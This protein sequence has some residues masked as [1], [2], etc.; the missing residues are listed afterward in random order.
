[1]PAEMHP[2]HLL[3]APYC[4]HR[5]R[6]HAN[7]NN[8]RQHRSLASALQAVAR[9]G[10]QKILDRD[11]LLAAPLRIAHG[12]VS[13]L[14]QIRWTSGVLYDIP[15]KLAEGVSPDDRLRTHDAQILKELHWPILFTT[16]LENTARQ[17][18]L[19]TAADRS[20]LAELG[21]ILEWSAGT[22]R[23]ASTSPRSLTLTTKMLQRRVACSVCMLNFFLAWETPT[24][25]W[26][27]QAQTPIGAPSGFATEF[28][29]LRNRIT[30]GAAGGRGSPGEEL[31]AVTAHSAP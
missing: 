29:A 25:F 6:S 1:M 8:I 9:P 22:W 10:V 11:R 24:S 16:L 5:H 7:F 17:S 3:Q 13:S 12:S 23:G 26:R 14:Q 31:S 28:A 30:G 4:Q 19:R 15:R 27:V 21:S 2:L 20:R 18:A